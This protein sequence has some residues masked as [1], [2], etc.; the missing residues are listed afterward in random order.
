MRFFINAAILILGLIPMPVSSQITWNALYDFEFRKGGPGSSLDRNDV[1]ND[2][3]SFSIHRFQLF[4]NA[5]VDDQISFTAKLQNNVIFG[6]KLKEVEIQLAYITFR[7]LFGE[8]INISAGRILTPFGLFPKRQ[9]S[10]ENPLIGNPLY[11]QYQLKVSPSL[12]Y[13]PDLVPG[14]VYGGL[15]TMYLGGYNTGVEVFGSA[16]DGL[17]DYDVAMMNAPMSI[18]ISDINTTGDFSYQGRLGFQPFM[19]LGFGFSGNYGRFM[20]K[21]LGGYRPVIADSTQKDFDENLDRY[22]Q[23]AWGT[24]LTLSWAYYTV[25]A[26][27]I[28][29]RWSSPFIRTDIYPYVS[30]LRKGEE[31]N[32]VNREFLVDARVDIPFLVG[33]YVAGRFNVLTFGDIEDPRN[34]SFSKAWDNRVRRYAAGAGYKLART[35]VLK[36]GYE[37]TIIDIDPQPYLNV[38]GLQLSALF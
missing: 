22:K 36:V 15:S 1:M 24:D 9:L 8:D 23:V 13:R 33:L 6:E 14:D 35:V 37:W 2:N 31:L 32:L 30:G 17:L 26:E 16:L 10:R 25:V 29:N 21:N 11:F 18:V 20:D 7:G 4:V 12:G 28:H 3:A 19:F 38:W 34:R 5:L 27:Y